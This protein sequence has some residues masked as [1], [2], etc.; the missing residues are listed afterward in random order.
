MPGTPAMV[1]QHDRCGNS[2]HL[3][4]VFG[5][6]AAGS[7]IN[8]SYCSRIGNISTRAVIG[9]AGSSMCSQSGGNRCASL[10]GSLENL[11]H[12]EIRRGLGTDELKRLA[13]PG[14]LVK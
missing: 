10:E 2:V 5:Q 7:T 1:V 13:G 11:L 12:S 4:F 9:W 14:L 3:L 8:P 6:L